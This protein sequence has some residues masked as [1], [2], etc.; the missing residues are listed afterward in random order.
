MLLQSDESAR[1]FIETLY[2]YRAEGHYLLHEFVVMR[3]HIHLLLTPAT[4]TTIERAVQLIKGGFSHRYGKLRDH[5]GGLW[6]RSYYDRRIRD[7]EECAAARQYIRENPVKAGYVTS[8]R[9]YA[10]GSASGLY[11][12]DDLPQRLKAVARAAGTQA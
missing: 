4:Q 12:L 2:H 9:D 3:E 6:Q 10:H 8:A 5:R 1:L 7:A 11:Q